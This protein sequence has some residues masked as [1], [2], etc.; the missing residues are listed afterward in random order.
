[1][2]APADSSRAV[3]P[4]VAI[5]SLC[6]LVALVASAVHGEHLSSRQAMAS[7]T[8]TEMR[9]LVELLADDTFEGRAAG[10]RGGRAAAGRGTRS[11]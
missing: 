4:R 9:T 2:S 5:W 7:I 3:L 8:S 11:G 10:S 6:P 1:M